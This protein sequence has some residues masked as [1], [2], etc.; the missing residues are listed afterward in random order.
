MPSL[1]DIAQAVTPPFVSGLL[2]RNAAGNA[3]NTLAAGTD[4]ASGTI[5]QSGT[6]LQALYRQIL[7]SQQ[8]QLQPYQQAGVASLNQLQTGLAPGG[9][10][11]D[12]YSPTTGPAAPGAFNWQPTN[13]SSDPGYQFRL[14]EGLKAINAGANAN[15][16][17]FSGG[18][19]KSV[20]N[21]AQDSASQEAQASFNR[22]LTTYGTNA[23]EYQAGFD[24]NRATTTDTFNRL[25]GVAQIGQNAANQDVA[26]Q[27]DFANRS[28]QNS[29]FTA[30]ELANLETEKAS[31]IAS[32]DVAKANALTAA[33][34][35]A[36]KG[37]ASIGP[38]KDI[39]TYIKS[40]TSGAPAAA[41]GVA[42]PGASLTG[43]AGAATS[44]A[45]AIGSG[46]AGTGVLGLG[47]TTIAPNA[48]GG[49]LGLGVPGATATA[50]S[51]PLT[52]Y[53]GGGLVTSHGALIGMMTN[54]I[55][56]GVAAAIIG[57][58]ALLKSQAHHEAN[59]WVQHFQN[60]FDAGMDQMNRQF[61]SAAQSGQLSKDQAQQIRD[62][63]AAA[64]K[65]YEAKRQ[66]FAKQG[67]DKKKV[68]GQ[69]L[70]TFDKYYGP[71]GSDFLNKMDNVIAGLA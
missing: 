12:P 36:A 41:G 20:N 37:L 49:T 13:L 21:Y 11:T 42:L 45:P 57:V 18:T 8:G 25:Q 53:A 60:K 19:L 14:Q 67:S 30:A 27:G 32:G 40:L 48:M 58:T 56:I 34:S 7:A 70:E 43:V 3:S 65:E 59:D 52:G 4:T 28:G 24:R 5:R 16:T 46:A 62:E 29:Q 47:S 6:D 15:G 2:N 61:Q 9:G 51:A 71:D 68:A 31:A 23:N 38:A 63:A 39:S 69:A 66:D 33:I 50:A 10:L 64:M 54:P 55:T 44:A 26:A 35:G 22:D 1:L 17:R